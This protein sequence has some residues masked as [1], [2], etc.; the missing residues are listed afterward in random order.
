M[1]VIGITGGVG[2]GKSQVMD[3][4]SKK[5]DS[6]FLK[7]D[8]LAKELEQK[9]GPCYEPLLG[10]F[11][12]SILGENAEIDGNKMAAAIFEGGGSTLLKRVDD[13]VHPAVKREILKRIDIAR[14]KNIYDFFFIEAALLIEDGYESICDELWYIYASQ[15]VRAKRLKEVRG[16]SDEKIKGIFASQLDEDTFRKHCL[17]VIDNNGTIDELIGNVD[18]VLRDKKG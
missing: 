16:Y 10:L 9:G 12:E 11:G 3:I 2:C 8:N 13:I 6:Y 17:T 15:Q 18:R 5:S 4:L 1:L 7:A 14:G